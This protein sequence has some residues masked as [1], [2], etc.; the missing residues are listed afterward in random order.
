[1]AHLLHRLYG[2]DAPGNMYRNVRKLWICGMP[3]DRQTDRQTDTPIAIIRPHPG[4]KVS[5]LYRTEDGLIH[6]WTNR[7]AYALHSPHCRYDSKLDTGLL[8]FAATSPVLTILSYCR[9]IRATRCVTL[10][11][12]YTKVDGQCDKLATVV[13][14][15]IFATV[16]VLSWNFYLFGVWNE[17]PEASI[18]VF[19]KILELS[20]N[21][22]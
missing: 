6:V 17:V 10:T 22:L 20:F 1:M 4:G 12:W 19:L 18:V 13:S 11:M 8:C 2:V 3:A 15:T 16:D 9:W 14:Q 21:T 7:A 5:M